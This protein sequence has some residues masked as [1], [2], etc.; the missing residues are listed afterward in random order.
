MC[1]LKKESDRKT[2][3]VYKLVA[4]FKGNYYA[5]FS[6][7][8]IKKGLVENIEEAKLGKVPYFKK[9]ENDGADD[10]FYNE[11]AVGRTSGFAEKK[12]ALKLHSIVNKDN[13]ELP[14]TVL[15]MKLSTDLVE[16]TG[17]GL[18]GLNFIDD[19][20]VYAGKKIVS[21]EEIE[22]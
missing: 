6:G 5:P 17:D 1:D 3:T 11:L 19:T 8:L 20:V 22:V 13:E 2:T 18:T 9:Y 4:V 16:G 12:V 14:L 21:F 10:S 15:K 7:M